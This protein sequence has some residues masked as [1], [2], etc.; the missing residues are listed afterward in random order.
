MELVFVLECLLGD[1]RLQ[2]IRSSSDKS[3]AG[4]YN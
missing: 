3:G 1:Q 4:G 2:G